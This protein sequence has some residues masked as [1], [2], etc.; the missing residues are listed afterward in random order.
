MSTTSTLD[1]LCLRMFGVLSGA[2]VDVVGGPA[3]PSSSW[4]RRLTFPSPKSRRRRP[5]K[6]EE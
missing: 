5:N 2:G 3:T 1:G 4:H 6:T